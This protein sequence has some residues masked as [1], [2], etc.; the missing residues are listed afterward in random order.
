MSKKLIRMFTKF[1]QRQFTKNV[2]CD[3]K[4][5]RYFI[6]VRKIRVKIRQ[7]EHGI[8]PAKGTRRTKEALHCIFLPCDGI[9]V[10]KGESVAGR[11]T[12]V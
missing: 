8:G 11:Y 1:N 12:E 3:K 7:T 4:Q 5:V 10:P 6:L 9:P 2:S